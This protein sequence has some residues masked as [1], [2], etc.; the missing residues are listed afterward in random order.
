MILIALVDFF[1]E[2]SVYLSLSREEEEEVLV[3][4]GCRKMYGI[5]DAF[6]IFS[7]QQQARVR[8]LYSRVE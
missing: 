1:T 6:Q 2:I 3:A 8:S 7:L 5:C 4:C